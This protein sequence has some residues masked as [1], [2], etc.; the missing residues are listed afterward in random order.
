MTDATK[1]EKDLWDKLDVI[2]KMVGATV[3]PLT[4]L[5]IGHFV[6]QSIET[7]RERDA[8]INLFTQLT[9]QRET[10]D[11]AL[12]KDMFQHIIQSVIGKREKLE[13]REQLLNLELLA[14]NFHDC[15]DLRSIF[16]DIHRQIEASKNFDLLVRLTSVAEEIRRRQFTV[17]HEMGNV[18]YFHVDLKEVANGEYGK[19]LVLR[20]RNDD[21]YK[22]ISFTETG[23]NQNEPK[24]TKKKIRVQALSKN[25][26][27]RELEVRVQILT[28]DKNKLSEPQKVRLEAAE[29]WA[30]FYD[31]PMI[32]NFRLKDDCR[33]AV[34]LNE[35]DDDA[36]KIA[37]V[38]FPG[39]RSSIKEKA[40]YGEIMQRLNQIQNQK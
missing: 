10:S 4:L 14:H 11:S 25:K 38:L 39:H 34:L 31:F 28:F 15:L 9:T 7:K 3:I 27:S 17:L 12:R 6:Q 33:C 35:F 5:V 32:D 24:E 8:K 40:Y 21:D 19:P 29:V 30:G 20:R 36:A 26:T 2:A 37:V 13:L 18:A 16:Y 1:K 22:W 23:I